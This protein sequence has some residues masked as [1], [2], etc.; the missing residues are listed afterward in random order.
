MTNRILIADDDPPARKV[1]AMHCQQHGFGVD[2][3][4]DGE[5]ALFY[6]RECPCQLVFADLTM[7]NMDGLELL[8]AMK[9]DSDLRNIPVLMISGASDM[10]RIGECLEAGAE[11]YITK[12]PFNMRLVL[13]RIRSALRREETQRLAEQLRRSHERDILA[14]EMVG[15][16]CHHFNQ[17]LTIAML[18][19]EMFQKQDACLRELFQTILSEASPELQTEVKALAQKVFGNSGS[20]DLESRINETDRHIHAIFSALDRISL[21]VR[22]TKSI[23]SPRTE[24]YPGGSAILDLE[25]SQRHVVLLADSIAPRCDKLSHSIQEIGFDSF[26]VADKLSFC[27]RIEQASPH[28]IV[29]SVDFLREQPVQAVIK[30][31]R[32][33]SDVYVLVY[34]LAEDETE[35]RMLLDNEVD[36]YLILFSESFE[37]QLLD[38][39]RR[40]LHPAAR[41]DLVEVPPA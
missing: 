8:K 35:S 28:A 13:A 10:N 9:Q 40:M 31:I 38:E 25:A 1:L 20:V 23:I 19:F 14:K 37:L 7:P 34:G 17:P 27:Q 6:L 30:Q 21:L 4:G 3:V 5:E 26:T 22:K 16:I 33:E 2:E 11:D 12:H 29:V 39:L 24:P 36:F 15:A 32:K 41:T 18:S